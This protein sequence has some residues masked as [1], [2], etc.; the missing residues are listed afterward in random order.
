MGFFITTALVQ[1]QNLFVSYVPFSKT[2]VYQ[3]GN[4]GAACYKGSCHM[5]HVVR[6]NHVA[7]ELNF[8]QMS[9]LCKCIHD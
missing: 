2:R 9:N 4:S 8:M 7:T 6:A 1:C 5:T 3:V